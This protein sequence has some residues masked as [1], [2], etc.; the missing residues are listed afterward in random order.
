MNAAVDFAAVA[1]DELA[2]SVD[3]AKNEG[4]TLSEIQAAVAK[5]YGEQSR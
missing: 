2:L 5:A 1:L 4:V 3:A